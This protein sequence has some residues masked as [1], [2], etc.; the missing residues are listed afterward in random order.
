MLL[1]DNPL[2]IRTHSLIKERIALLFSAVRSDWSDWIEEHCPGRRELLG[3]P[4]QQP[5]DQRTPTPNP[6]QPSVRPSPQ[7]SPPVPSVP[8][9]SQPTPP[10]PS[11]PPQPSRQDQSPHPPTPPRIVIHTSG[12]AVSP[13]HSPALSTSPPP[14]HMTICSSDDSEEE[15]EPFAVPK[16]LPAEMDEDE[17]DSLVKSGEMTSWWEAQRNA[18]Q[19]QVR[20]S[21]I[22]TISL[23]PSF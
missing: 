11:S 10:A 20:I 15:P 2:P 13:C 6:P 1:G 18:D 17:W 12:S 4:T 19:D 7:P 23:T 3:Q 21:V 22:F 16:T 8:P 5:S 14:D 9:P